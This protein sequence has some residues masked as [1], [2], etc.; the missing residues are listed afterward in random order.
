MGALLNTHTIYIYTE[1]IT[2]SEV[3]IVNNQFDYHDNTTFGSV[4]TFLVFAKYTRFVFP[5]CK[6]SDLIF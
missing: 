6:A 3:F 2:N 5:K 1:L 4:I